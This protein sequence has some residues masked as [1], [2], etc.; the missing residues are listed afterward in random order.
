MSDVQP[1]FPIFIPSVGR[2]RLRYTVKALERM[3]VERY[4][5]VV[6]QREFEQYAN[7]IDRERLIVLDESYKE[8]YHYC[9]DFALTKPTGSGPARN[10]IWDTSVRMGAAWHWVIDDNIRYFARFHQNRKHEV[11]SGAFFRAMEE[12]CLRY[13]NVAMAG[14]HYRFFVARNAKK[15]V[16][17][18]NTRIYSCNLIR[19]DVPFRWRGRYNEDTILSLDM[20]SKDWC[21]VLFASFQQDKYRTLVCKGGNTD[22]IYK[23]GTGW[24]SYMLKREYPQIVR[25]VERYGRIHHHVDYRPFV[26]NQLRRKPGIEIAAEPNEFGMKLTAQT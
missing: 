7:V 5:V 17:T 11:L 3:H 25:I 19:N 21:T 2:W 20:L 10:F 15:P 4:F 22:T 16:F 23:E 13:E 24:K 12:F 9:D 18:L 14:P 1:L 8:R 6:E 26:R